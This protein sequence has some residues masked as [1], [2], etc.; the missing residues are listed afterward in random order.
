MAQSP[1]MAISR[2][3]GDRLMH[4]SMRPWS[5]PIVSIRS[6]SAASALAKSILMSV[7]SVGWL[8]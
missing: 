6:T 1:R 8:S 4:T 5:L 7:S 2:P 3:R